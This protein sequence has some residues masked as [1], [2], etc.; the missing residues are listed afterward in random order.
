MQALDNMLKNQ[1]MLK[2]IIFLIQAPGNMLKH[3]NML[4]IL[5]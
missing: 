4:E 3:Q 1:N 2:D 5:S